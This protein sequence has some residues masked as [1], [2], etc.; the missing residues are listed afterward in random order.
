MLLV[1]KGD[2][3]AV[4]LSFVGVPGNIADGPEGLEPCHNKSAM[5]TETPATNQIM[6]GRL[7]MD[8]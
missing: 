7:F 3:V 6:E 4:A 8:S 1:S 2:T 5:T